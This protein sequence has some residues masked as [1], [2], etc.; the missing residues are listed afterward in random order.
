MQYFEQDDPD[1]YMTKVKYI[2]ENDVN[3]MDLVFAEEE[4]RNSQLEKVIFNHRLII[5]SSLNV[6]NVTKSSHLVPYMKCNNEKMPFFV[7]VCN[8]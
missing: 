2:L 1:L 5:Y 6:Y 3:D 7:L 4:S 8:I